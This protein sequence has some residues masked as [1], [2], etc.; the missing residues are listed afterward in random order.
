MNYRA[1]ATLSTQ[2]VNPFAFVLDLYFL[3]TSAGI[4]RFNKQ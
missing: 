2:Y 1:K 3:Q 4:A